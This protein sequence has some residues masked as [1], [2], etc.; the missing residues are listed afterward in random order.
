[1]K[2]VILEMNFT[3]LTVLVCSLL[4]ATLSEVNSFPNGAGGCAGGVAAVGGSHL[5]LTD[6]RLVSNSTLE[7]GGVIVQIGNITLSVNTPLDLATLEDHTITIIST[8]FPIRGILIRVEADGADTSN[9]LTPGLLTKPAMAC[10]APIVGTTHIDNSDK[11]EL[12]SVIRFDESFDSVILDITGVFVNSPDGSVYVYS[13]YYVNFVSTAPISSVPTTAPTSNEIPT[14]VPIMASVPTVSPVALE[15]EAPSAAPVV[16]ETTEPTEAPV[17]VETPAPTIT[18]A[19]EETT[20][21]TASP[22]VATE[23]P[24]ASPLQT[25]IFTESPVPTPVQMTPEPS[26]RGGGKVSG[27]GMGMMSKVTDDSSPTKAPSAGK[28]GMMKG[29]SMSE[30]GE[31]KAYKH[32]MK[33]S[34]DEVDIMDK[35]HSM[36][37][38]SKESVK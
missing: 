8:E 31:S 1:M 24:T 15:T 35:K 18:P 28:K 29:M 17:P 32:D 36:A 34:K 4:L 13:R 16:I 10:V 26:L 25:P 14:V 2:T 22:I 27:K 6:G 11:S 20:R 21:P 9:V 30:T 12:T 3:T 7:T 5:G 37:K 38:I 33:K 19:V 23:E